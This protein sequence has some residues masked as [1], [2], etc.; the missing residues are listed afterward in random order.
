M[1]SA[2]VASTSRIV[3]I[4][5]KSIHLSDETPAVE[6]MLSLERSS[7]RDPTPL[8]L[9][10]FRLVQLK[11][12]GKQRKRYLANATSLQYASLSV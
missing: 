6:N 7:K 5:L 11:D 8:Y 10:S 4:I 1:N 3:A 2:D 9:E 12:H